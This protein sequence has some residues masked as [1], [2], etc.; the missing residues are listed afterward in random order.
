[1]YY[2]LY[3]HLQAIL[4]RKLVVPEMEELMKEEAKLSVTGQNGMIRVQCRHVRF[5]FFLYTFLNLYL[6][7]L[8]FIF[9]GVF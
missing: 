2:I 8:Y 1:M 6:T 3:L 5:C 7:V 4:S 9:D